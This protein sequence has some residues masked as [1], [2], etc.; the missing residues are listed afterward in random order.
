MPE[1]IQSPSHLLSV[2]QLR[3]VQGREPRPHLLFTELLG[4]VTVGFTYSPNVRMAQLPRDDFQRHP[5]S[6]QIA[7]VGV[8]QTMKNKRLGQ[9]GL[10]DSTTKQIGMLTAPELGLV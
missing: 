7:G 8:P 10:A 5:L 9:A 4:D 6:D 2:S 3:I 1:F